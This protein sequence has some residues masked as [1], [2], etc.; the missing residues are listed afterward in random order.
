MMVMEK[1]APHHTRGK[2]K[3]Q[4]NGGEGGEQ[5]EASPSKCIKDGRGASERYPS[6]LTLSVTEFPEMTQLFMVVVE[7]EA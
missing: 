7:E 2:R 6:L 5:R 3:K 4:G 1:G